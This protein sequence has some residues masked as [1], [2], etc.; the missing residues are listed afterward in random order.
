MLEAIF[1]SV[2]QER[3]LLYIFAKGEV[4]GSE[5]SKFYE[6]DV[7]PIQKQLEKL[8]AG[9]VIVSTKIGRTILYSFN[10]RYAFLKELKA[11]LKKAFSFLP[12]SNQK[13]Y[14]HTRTRPRRQGKPL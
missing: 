7:S 5:I 14:T 12:E 9:G 3:V 13:S 1:G 11:M 8:E 10:P 2:N 4:Y 6:T